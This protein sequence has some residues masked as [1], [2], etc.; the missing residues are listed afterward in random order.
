MSMSNVCLQ[1]KKERGVRV[2]SLPR[3]R[4]PDLLVAKTEFIA[5]KN[6]VLFSQRTSIWRY[7]MKLTDS[8]LSTL[9]NPA[10]SI[11]L[12]VKTSG[13]TLFSGMAD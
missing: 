5:P 10:F 11:F 13:V 1:G 4:P 8:I 6:Y 9:I 12:D 7:K 2:L 3:T